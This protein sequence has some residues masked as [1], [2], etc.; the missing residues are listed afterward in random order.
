MPRGSH[1]GVVLQVIMIGPR[2]AKMCFRVTDYV[3]EVSA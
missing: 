3:T 2:A 1:A